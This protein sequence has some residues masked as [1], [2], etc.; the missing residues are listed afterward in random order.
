MTNSKTVYR[1]DGCIDLMATKAVREGTALM[2]ADINRAIAI[3]F[4]RGFETFEEEI[5]QDSW[6]DLD[7]YASEDE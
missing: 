6:N 7:L 4:G 3:A 2:P 1:K 5:E